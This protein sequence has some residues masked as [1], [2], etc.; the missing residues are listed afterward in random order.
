MQR[1]EGSRADLITRLRE[2]ATGWTHFGNTRL[3]EA[4]RTGAQRLE[5]GAPSVR[6]G[7]TD[8]VV[9]SE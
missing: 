8:Y 5:A 2:L 4:S 3:A 6:A 1:I 7:V 9:T